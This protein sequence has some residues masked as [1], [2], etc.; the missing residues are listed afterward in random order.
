MTLGCELKVLDALNG[1]RLWLKEIDL[2]HDLKDLNPM[3]NSGLQ[4]T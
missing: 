4:M 1:S 3:N 2:G